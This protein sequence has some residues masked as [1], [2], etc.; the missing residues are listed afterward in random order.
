M[1]THYIRREDMTDVLAMERAA[2]PGG[3]RWSEDDYRDFL[4]QDNTRMWVADEDGETL[5]LL[6][7]EVEQ[8]LRLTRVA[9]AAG[10]PEG[11]A[12]ALLRRAKAF[13]S[14]QDLPDTAV[15]LVHERDKRSIEVY[16]RAPG[17]KARVV[18]NAFHKD[19]GIEFTMRLE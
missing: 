2:F 11:V 19:D 14:E 8:Q 10:A 9:V 13:A 5:G 1:E 3:L 16:R 4:E 17:V 12:K 7:V 6:L 15:A 18:A